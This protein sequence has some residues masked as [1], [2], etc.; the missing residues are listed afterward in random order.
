MELPEDPMMLFSV[1]NM[2]LRDCYASLDELCEDMNISKD[3]LIGE[4]ES[5]GFEYNAEQNKF[6]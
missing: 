2:K 3:I 5:I 6:W 4:L 1:I